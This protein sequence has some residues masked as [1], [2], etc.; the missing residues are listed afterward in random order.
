MKI[1]VIVKLNPFQMIVQNNGSFEH[2]L[3]LTRP[4][5]ELNGNW[6]RFFFLKDFYC[7][8]T[9]V[10]NGGC[11]PEGVTGSLIIIPEVN[12]EENVTMILTTKFCFKKFV[13][14]MDSFISVWTTAGGLHWNAVPTAIHGRPSLHNIFET[15]RRIFAINNPKVI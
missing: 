7:C 6:P 11:K 4:R 9:T 3:S 13:N 15:F 12:A 2:I 1:C 8:S 5:H 10:V 14:T